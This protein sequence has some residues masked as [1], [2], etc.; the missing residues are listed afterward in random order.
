MLTGLALITALTAPTY[1]KGEAVE[2]LVG[3][4]KGCIGNIVDI[5]QPPGEDVYDLELFWCEKVYIKGKFL[6]EGLKES[7]IH[8]YR[9]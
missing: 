9:R 2:V 6:L 5:T 4:Y 8:G 7:E 3:K 1:Y